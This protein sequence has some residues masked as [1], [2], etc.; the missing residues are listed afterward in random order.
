M[1]LE[2]LDGADSKES[3]TLKRSGGTLKETADRW[4]SSLWP[5]LGQSQTKP[6]IEYILEYKIKGNRKTFILSILPH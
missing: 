1:S 5:K 2:P 3:F 4:Q 6:G